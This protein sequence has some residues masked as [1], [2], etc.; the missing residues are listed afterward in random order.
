M[1][2]RSASSDREMDSPPDD[3]WSFIHTYENDEN[4]AT[5]LDIATWAYLACFVH[6][7]EP[8]EFDAL[9]ST[10]SEGLGPPAH[11]QEVIEAARSLDDTEGSTIA[12]LPQRS[13]ARIYTRSARPF[14]RRTHWTTPWSS[15]TR[16]GI[17]GSRH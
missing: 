14:L 15:G 17:R 6:F 7:N 2:A 11:S 3:L 5:T 12:F 4:W 9:I 1:G 10:A 13:S 8:D 16:D